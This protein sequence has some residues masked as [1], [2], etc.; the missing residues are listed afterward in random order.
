M[1]TAP[2]PT[3]ASTFRRLM[4]TSDPATLAAF[5]V[6]S[7]AGARI[8]RS[9][10][11]RRGRSAG[12]GP[13]FDQFGRPGPAGVREQPHAL[14]D[15]HGIGEQG[16][17]VDQLVVEQPADQVA[18]AVHLQLTRRPGFQLADGR[19]TVTGEDGR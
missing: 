5:L 19:R 2:A 13:R 12:G 9:P 8:L 7:L 18:A 3:P 16:D 1:L 11:A 14:A 10:F 17:L 15:D 4:R 6:A